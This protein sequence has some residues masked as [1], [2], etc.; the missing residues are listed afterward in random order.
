ML[1]ASK[2]WLATAAI[3]LTATLVGCE[4][5]RKE[6]EVFKVTGKVLVDGK[7]AEGVLLGIHNSEPYDK[8]F[9][10]APQGQTD[11]D[12]NLIISTYA[13]GDGLPPGNYAFTFTWQDFNL[14]SRSYSGPDKLKKKYADP[15][16]SKITSAVKGPVDLGEIQ[17]TTK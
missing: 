9:P 12:G 16:T 5:K 17:L 4:E 11:A 6:K 10:T 3:V 2:I 1:G 13:Q 7:P 15:K 8:Q 14:M